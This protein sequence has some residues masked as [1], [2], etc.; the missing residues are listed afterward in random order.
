M[1]AV[2]IAIFGVAV[3]A[4]SPLQAVAQEEE[5]DKG[6]EF[7]L[8]AGTILA[9]S[10]LGDDAYQLSA[11]PNLGVTYSDVFF[12]SLLGGVGY[13]VIN[14]QGWRA[15]LIAKYDFGR[16]EDGD[17]LFLI[18]GDETDDLAG[19]GDVDGGFELGGFI[20]YSY[21]AFQGKVELRQAVN[22][23]KGFIGEAAA[24]FKGNFSLFGLPAFFS[25]GP[26]IVFGDSTYNGAFFDVNASQAAASGL[27]EFD[28]GAGL[29][30]YGLHASLVLSLTEQVSLLGLAGYDRLGGDPADSSLVQERGSEDQGMVGL[31]L[32]Y[33]F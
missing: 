4:A 12:A 19:L 23:H 6:W 5:A 17:N 2:K 10:Y 13:N 7:T 28:A 33:R 15:G 30:S 1:N 31:M 9:P 22:G 14:T 27:S 24:K 16:D 26:E 25:V 8:G 3:L 21:E 18:A 20:E 29:V 11:V 32:N